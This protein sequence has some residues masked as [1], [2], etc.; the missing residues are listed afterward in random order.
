MYTV[1]VILSL[2]I[3]LHKHFFFFILYAELQKQLWSGN[4]KEVSNKGLS[5]WVCSSPSDSLAESRS[6]ELSIKK[7]VT[8]NMLYYFSL[9]MMHKNNKRE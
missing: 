7:N 5:V 8:D 1:V 4:C 3:R 6:I 9:K 2:P